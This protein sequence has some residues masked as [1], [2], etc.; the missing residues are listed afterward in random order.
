MVL[1]VAR[2]TRGVGY[3]LERRARLPVLAVAGGA[4]ERQVRVAAP[5]RPDPLAP[6][7][8]RGVPLA[9][10]NAV[11]GVVAVARWDGADVP[12]VERLAG[13]MEHFWS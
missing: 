3:K 6:G 13:V 7:R 12:P 10:I 5:R 4:S 8:L 9:L 2:L 11:R 1:P